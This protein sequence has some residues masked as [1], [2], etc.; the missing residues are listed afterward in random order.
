MYN[1]GRTNGNKFKKTNKSK[2]EQGRAKVNIKKQEAGKQEQQRTFCWSGSCVFCCVSLQ[3]SQG[4]PASPSPHSSATL[5]SGRASW[6][7]RWDSCCHLTQPSC[8]SSQSQHFQIP[9]WQVWVGGCRW[10]S[11]SL[12][13]VTE[14]LTWGKGFGAF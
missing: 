1:R 3:S 7:P 8:P 14:T 4:S 2:Q 12:A 10:F 9:S 6:S 13:K 5:V 11:V